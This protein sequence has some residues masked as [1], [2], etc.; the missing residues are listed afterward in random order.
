MGMYTDDTNSVLALATSLVRRGGLDPQ[1]AAESYGQFWLSNPERGYPKRYCTGTAVGGLARYT[2]AHTHIYIC[3]RT[4]TCILEYKYRCPHMS[5]PS[6]LSLYRCRNFILFAAP[7][8]SLPPC[9]KDLTS[10]TL[11]LRCFLMAHMQMGER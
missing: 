6:F 9:S 5:C 7:S 8:L 10:V 2:R 3:T 11:A 4:R 1:D